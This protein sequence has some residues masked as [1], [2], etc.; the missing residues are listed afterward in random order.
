MLKL[1]VL[2]GHLTSLP[3]SGPVLQTVPCFG[4]FLQASAADVVLLRGGCTALQG[5][6]PPDVKLRPEQLGDIS[7]VPELS[8]K[9]TTESTDFNVIF[10]R[11]PV[12][13]PTLDTLHL[14][15]P[16]VFFL[17]VAVAG[18]NAAL[19]ATE[20]DTAADP[21]R[22]PG[23]AAPTAEVAAAV[24]PLPTANNHCHYRCYH[25]LK[26]C[27]GEDSRF[28]CT[29]LHPFWDTV[30]AGLPQDPLSGDFSWDLQVQCGGS[31]RFGGVWGLPAKSAGGPC[32]ADASR[33]CSFA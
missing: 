7:E 26:G 18:K 32:L 14:L 20:A 29:W 1:Q 12:S 2:R 6:S 4:S 27:F 21:W 24:D 9:G 25:S 28:G 31:C 16:E 13:V 11:E 10:S 5:R 15:H 23:D 33:N 19:N 3:E 22:S 8:L 30:L 17:D